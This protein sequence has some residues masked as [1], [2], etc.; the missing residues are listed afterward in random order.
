MNG[1]SM[2]IIN[3]FNKIL[4]GVNLFGIYHRQDVARESW[5]HLQKKYPDKI[6]FNAIQFESENSAPTDYG[7]PPKFVLERS[8]K[9]IVPHGTKELPILKDILDY[10]YSQVKDDPN[11]THFGWINSDI[12]TTSI[13]VEYF[14]NH[15]V[16]ALAASRLDIKEVKNFGQILEN[17]VTPL[18][19]EPA[20]FD[21]YIFSKEWWAKYG[22]LIN[23]YLLGVPEFDPVI[24]GI[25]AVTGG[26][27]YN[28]PQQPM[29]CHIQH[30]IKWGSDSPEKDWNINLKKSNP[31]DHLCFNM[32]HYHLQHNLCH[33]KPWGAFMNPEPG[34]KEFTKDFFDI[35]SLETSK[36]IKYIG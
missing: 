25:I 21:S 14:Q 15:D 30:P 2:I 8:S 26:E 1:L 29:I 10:L 32:M 31:F 27:L 9:D 18:R 3:M 16:R 35:F 7:I 5:I 17:G 13:F 28:D 20:G 36:Q 33:R 24:S 11:Y 12:I 23:P 4:I 19:F 34:E 6:E 22:H